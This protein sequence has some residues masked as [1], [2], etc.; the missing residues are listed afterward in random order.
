MFL[1]SF[2]VQ[3]DHS[4]P[5]VEDLSV[6]G[7]A[8]AWTIGKT[9]LRYRL[10]GV[11]MSEHRATVH[12]IRNE[13]EFTPKGYSRDHLWKL[14]NGNEVHASAAPE[15][16]GNPDLVDPERAFVAALSSCHMLTFLAVAARDGFVVDEYQDEAVG[17]ME[18]NHEKRIA[19]TKVVLR[20]RITWNSE[21]PTSEELEKLHGKAHKHC[22][23]ANSVAT[24]ITVEF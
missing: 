10:E 6:S 12:W 5:R 22:F 2:E 13:R 4:S 8:E 20:P 9:V 3:R 23:I 16:L 1:E 18:R 19:I 15:Y 14:G 11:A 17:L 7:D 21:P 24:V